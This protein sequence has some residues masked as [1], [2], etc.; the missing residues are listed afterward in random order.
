MTREKERRQRGE[1]KVKGRVC[2]RKAVV[3]E[4]K[5]VTVSIRGERQGLGDGAREIQGQAKR[6][7]LIQRNR[8]HSK[9]AQLV[10][11]EREIK[12][13]LGGRER[14]GGQQIEMKA[15]VRKGNE[16][17][18][19]AHQAQPAVLTNQIHSR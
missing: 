3:E 15:G 1:E 4:T 14:S 5:K 11:Q 9:T 17:T 7:Q 6:K 19:A 13:D 8:I 2:R 10:A 18:P 12:N 16:K